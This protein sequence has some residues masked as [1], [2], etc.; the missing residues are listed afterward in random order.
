MQAL[1]PPR[2]TCWR[3][4]FYG[5]KDFLNSCMGQGAPA[6]AATARRLWQIL[7]KSPRG[8]VEGL[9]LHGGPLQSPP[10]AFCWVKFRKGSLWSFQENS[11]Q[12]GHRCEAYKAQSVASPKP[13]AL[14][15]WQ[16]HRTPCE[17]GGRAFAR[18]CPRQA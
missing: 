12:Q 15:C 2:H 17:R 7:D 13:G 14:L 8:A 10:P 3:T 11:C 5:K 4:C 16:G 18:G 9:P 6:P 1:H